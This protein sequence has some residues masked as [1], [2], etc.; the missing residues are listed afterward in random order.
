MISLIEQLEYIKLFLE[1]RR[2]M[3]V[4]PI[5]RGD[6]APPSQHHHV[7]LRKAPKPMSKEKHKNLPKRRSSK[8][9]LRASDDPPFFG[10][11]R[12]DKS[13]KDDPDKPDGPEYTVS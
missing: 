10:W 3:K 8:G 11:G 5:M 9:G 2:P 1:A 4:T 13:P 12:T 7:S 6:D